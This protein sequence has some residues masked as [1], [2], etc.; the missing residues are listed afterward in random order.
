MSLDRFKNPQKLFDRS[1]D[2]YMNH[3][4]E[5]S[6]DAKRALQ[7]LEALAMEIEGNEK[8]IDIARRHFKEQYESRKN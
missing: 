1:Y 7:N 8:K 2:L 6:E 3:C 4:F 5:S